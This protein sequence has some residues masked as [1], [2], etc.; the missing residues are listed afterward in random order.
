MRFRKKEINTYT[1]STER[2][3]DMQIKSCSGDRVLGNDNPYKLPNYTNLSISGSVKMG[4]EFEKFMVIVAM[5]HDIMMGGKAFMFNGQLY[6]LSPK[7]VEDMKK[8]ISERVEDTPDDVAYISK[9]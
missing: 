6:D 4:P 9:P 7:E 1:R 3:V 2:I 8:F 5:N